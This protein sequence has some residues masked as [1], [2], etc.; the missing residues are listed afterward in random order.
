[1]IAQLQ[2]RRHAIIRSPTP[3]VVLEGDVL[4]ASK[5]R[6]V[7]HRLALV[8]D[9]AACSPDFFKRMHDKQIACLTYHK[10]PAPPWPEDEF[11]MQSVPL[12]SGQIVSSLMK[13]LRSRTA[14][15]AG[16]SPR[17]TRLSN[18]LWLREI[19]K[20]AARIGLGQVDQ[21]I[22]LALFEFLKN[23]VE[24]L[25]PARQRQPALPAVTSAPRLFSRHSPVHVLRL[26]ATRGTTGS[27]TRKRLPRPTSLCSSILPPCWEMMP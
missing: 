3:G 25:T 12:V 23:L 1:M 20:V 8:V 26:P 13:Q 7:P 14:S 27:H 18:G 22:H 6:Q 21:D 17:G 24:G 11:Q 9:R 4:P 15:K 5:A 10:Y 16:S 2:H 19:G